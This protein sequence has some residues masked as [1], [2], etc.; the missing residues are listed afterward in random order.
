MIIKLC[1]I[2]GFQYGTFFQTW[3]EKQIQYGDSFGKSFQLSHVFSDMDRVIKSLSM[4]LSP[5]FQ[6]S[7]VFSDMDSIGSSGI[8]LSFPTFQL[9]HV[10]SDMD[11]S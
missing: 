1:V 5:K 3:I 11:S 9:S 10:F 6:L 4:I 8:I 2:C 7:H